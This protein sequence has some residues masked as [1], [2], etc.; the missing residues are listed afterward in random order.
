M[1]TDTD[2]RTLAEQANGPFRARVAG[3]K[4][5]DGLV[6][7]D[8]QTILALLAE[9][10]RL[11]WEV[12]GYSGVIAERDAAERRVVALEKRLR[13][14][15]DIVDPHRLINY[16]SDREQSALDK[17]RALLA[18]SPTAS[19]EPIGERSDPP[20]AFQTGDLGNP[21]YEWCV[22]G[23]HRSQP[24]HAQPESEAGDE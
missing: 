2:L 8:P 16:W 21:T 11:Q 23:E 13:A 9:R 5:A 12:D 6:E 17:A 19:A 18:D 1:T 14:L 24:V 20:H 3:R 4:F 15:V 22:C 7:I 10:D